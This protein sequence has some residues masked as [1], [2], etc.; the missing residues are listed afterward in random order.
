MKLAFA[1]LSVFISFA[2][3]FRI[4]GWYNGD[5][6][7]INNIPFDIYTHIVTGSP[8]VN[9]DGSVECNKTDEQMNKIITLAHNNNVKVQYRSPIPFKT[10]Q[11]KNTT[12]IYKLNNYLNTINKTL[13]DCNV[14]GVEFDYE[15]TDSVSGKL[16]LITEKMSNEY[17]DFLSNVKIR[18]GDKLVSADIG[19]WGLPDEYIF[20][21]Y[22]WVNSDKLNNGNFDFVN[23]MSYNWNKYGNIWQW[24]MDYYVIKDM[25]GFNLEKVNLAVPYYSNNYTFID[26][27]LHHSEPSWGDFCDKCPN[28]DPNLNV[29]DNI[30]FIGKKMNY[31]LGKFIKEKGF[32]GVFPWTLNYDCLNKTVNNTLINWLNLG[33]Q[34]V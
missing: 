5:Y 25:W 31:E 18:V 32:G 23:I 4:V 15:F 13:V 11:V 7:D 24:I 16:G 20:G 1:L 6:N 22:P 33:I 2:Q 34:N 26:G 17:T 9:D 10:S 21:I 28:I 12:A 3:S 30:T 19:T 14:D 27:K 8:I 29:C